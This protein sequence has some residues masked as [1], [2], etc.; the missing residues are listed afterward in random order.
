MRMGLVAASAT[1]VWRYHTS[2]FPQCWG[3]EVSKGKNR[4]CISPCLKT[5]LQKTCAYRMPAGTNHCDSQTVFFVCTSCRT[6][7]V[8]SADGPL[9][10]FGRVSV[11]CWSV[12]R[13]VLSRSGMMWLVWFWSDVRTLN[14]VGF[15]MWSV[16]LLCDANVKWCD[17]AACPAMTAHVRFGLSVVRST[18]SLPTPHTAQ[19]HPITTQKAYPIP[20]HCITSHRTAHHIPPLERLTLQ[21]YREPMSHYDS[22][23]QSTTQ[24]Y[25]L[26]LL[27]APY[28]LS[29]I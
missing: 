6:S 26:V 2:S 16:M 19:L 17:A 21:D 29:T 3:A 28:H 5:A 7:A 11:V 1:F 24:Y 23:L 10:V 9:V 25:T 12:W 15:G 13:D 8:P 18:S 14:V 27:Q 22:V 4:S 20:S